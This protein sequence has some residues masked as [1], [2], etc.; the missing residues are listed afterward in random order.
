MSRIAKRSII[1]PK[2]VIV[3]INQ[4]KVVIKG[5]NGILTRILNNLV[6]IIYKNNILS[7]KSRVSSSEGWMHAGTSRSLINSM[8][9]GVT[10]GFYKKLN[11]VGVG[12]KF[13]LEGKNQKK[14]VMSLG[15]SHNVIYLVPDEISVELK[16]QTEILIKGIDK[17]LVGQVSANLRSCRKPDSYK[18]KGIRYS[19][20]FVK[21]KEAKKK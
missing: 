8:I 15:Y 19:D 3:Q 11:L 12:Y 7:F 21:V 13:S 5:K 20:E 17:R 1:V 6:E 9:I 16:S 4:Q 2:D 14:I 18:G 10:D